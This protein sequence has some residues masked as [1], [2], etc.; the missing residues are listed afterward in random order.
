M[1]ETPRTDSNLV[2][3]SGAGLNIET[4]FVQADFARTLERE[5]AEVTRQ[6]DALAEALEA[7]LP[8]LPGHACGEYDDARQALA[9]LKGDHECSPNVHPKP[10]V[11]KSHET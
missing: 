6:R 7:C 8:H 2:N 9:A 1:S 10:S 11:P 3:M 5:L 4:L